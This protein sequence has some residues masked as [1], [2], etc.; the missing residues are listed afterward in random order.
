MKTILTTVA[1]LLSTQVWAGAE[2]FKDGPLIMGYGK[3]APVMQSVNLTENRAFKVAFDVSEQGSIDKV[4]R[5]FDSL[6]R[7]LNMHIANGVSSDNLNLALVVHGKAGFDLLNNKVYQAKFNQDNPNQKLLAALMQHQVRIY[8]CGQSAAYHDI[9]N[10]DLQLGV[11]VAL[12]AM[13]AHAALQNE[14]YTLNPF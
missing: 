1:L 13:T 7:F 14:G 4:N 5:R 11:N 8:I 3:H 6:A 10:N 2:Q 12:S 9:K